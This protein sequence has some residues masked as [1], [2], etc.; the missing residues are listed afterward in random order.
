MNK[1][2]LWVSTALVYIFFA[3][4]LT[5]QTVIRM[6][7]FNKEN[8]PRVLGGGASTDWA[9]PGITLELLQMVAQRVGVRFEYKRMPWEKFYYLLISKSFFEKNPLLAEHIWDAVRDVQQT[10]AY[11]EMVAK[12][13][14]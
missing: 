3:S 14:N 4:P 6:V 13:L 10:E 11:R 2:L 7:Y 8:P 1:K 9:K 12:Y 5:A